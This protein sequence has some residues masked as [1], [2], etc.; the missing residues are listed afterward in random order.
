MNEQK[1]DAKNNAVLWTKWTKV[2]W[3]AFEQIY[4]GLTRDGIL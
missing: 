3:K 2:T 1:E 4:Q